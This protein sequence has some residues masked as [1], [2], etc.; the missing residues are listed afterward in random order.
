MTAMQV[1][2]TVLIAA[3]VTILLRTAPFLLF[4]SGKQSPAFITWLGN[5]LP[6]A[7]MM[8]LLVY[9]LKDI[10]LTT[11]PYGAPA[12]IAV[13]VTAALHV[14][15]RNSLVSIGGGT[16]CYMLLVQLVF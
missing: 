8:M 5:Q 6:R 12:L 13:A 1:L 7:V 3:G 15:K 14:W 11:A 2:I 16:L 9:C 10:S 4:P